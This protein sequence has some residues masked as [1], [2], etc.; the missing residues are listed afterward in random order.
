MLT[1]IPGMVKNGTYKPMSLF[2]EFEGK[3]FL[4][5]IADF[6]TSP[7][8]LKSE[9]TSAFSY[10]NAR[11]CAKLASKLANGGE[12]LMSEKTWN[13]LHS[14]PRKEAMMD[15]P[16]KDIIKKYFKKPNEVTIILLGG[17]IRSN[18]TKGGVNY[19]VKFDDSGPYSGEKWVYDNHYGYYGWMGYGGSILQWNP[20]KKIGFAFV[21]T[22]LNFLTDPLNH[23]GGH[24]QKL[25][26][27]C[28]N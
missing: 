4:S 19:H 3:N 27:D 28:T 7:D 15:T 16:G 2:K 6:S 14:E 26:T 22:S 20:E 24:L 9:S 25:V 23:R 8:A 17:P 11:G 10:G 13:K 12:D 1:S 5:D 21:P 18:F